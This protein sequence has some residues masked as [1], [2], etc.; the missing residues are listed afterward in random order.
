MTSVVLRTLWSLCITGINLD[1]ASGILIVPDGCSL[2]ISD[3]NCLCITPVLLVL[4][5]VYV[6]RDM[7]Y[8]ESSSLAAKKAVP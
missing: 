4:P 5:F 6:V 2:T 3:F 7:S 1:F 8:V